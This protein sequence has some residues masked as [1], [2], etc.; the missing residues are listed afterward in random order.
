MLGITKAFIQANLETKLPFYTGELC[1][2]KQDF[3]SPRGSS[4]D[5]MSPYLQPR[6]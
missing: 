5:S 2:L 4:A 1:S 6:Q 3:K